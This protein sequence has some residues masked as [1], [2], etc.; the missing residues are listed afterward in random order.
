MTMNH[1]TAIGIPTPN[2]VMAFAAQ[3]GIDQNLSAVLEMTRRIF[4]SARQVQVLVEEDPE[5]EDR[6]LVIEVHASLAVEQA[7]EASHRWHAE[8]FQCCPPTHVS[9]F[10]LGMRLSS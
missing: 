5:I 8:L 3:Q 7:V 1:A 9:F 10:R 2:E 6:Y 4:P